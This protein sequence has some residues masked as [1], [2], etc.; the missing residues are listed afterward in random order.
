MQPLFKFK[1]CIGAKTFEEVMT[2]NRILEWIEMDQDKDDFY[3]IEGIVNHRRNQKS[4][5][6]WEVLVEWA[7]GQVT[8]NDLTLTFQG[9]PVTVSM[10]AKKHGLLD[11]TGWR[12]CKRYARN[13]KTLGRA[14]NQVRLKNYRN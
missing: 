3:R 13:V 12:R 2:Y 10:C 7:S 14:A 8:W 1:C 4:P 6:G 11:K 5:S 9:D